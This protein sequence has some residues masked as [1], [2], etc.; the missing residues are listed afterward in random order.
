MRRGEAHTIVDII[1][2]LALKE[3][4]WRSPQLLANTIGPHCD[5]L[6][7]QPRGGYSRV[8]SCSVLHDCK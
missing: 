7:E 1:F 4:E 3:A 2:R 5:R 8:P 6:N